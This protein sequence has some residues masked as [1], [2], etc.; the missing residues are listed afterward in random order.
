VDVL[1]LVRSNVYFPVHA[2]GLKE[3]AGHLGFAWTA[4]EASGLQSVVWRR[5]WEQGRDDSY[6]QRLVVYNAE[7]CAALRLVTEHLEMIAANFDRDGGAEPGSPTS[8]ERVK[9]SKRGSDFRKWGHTAFLLPEFERASKCAWFDYQ[10]EKIVARR[11][12]KKATPLP[13][14]RRKARQPRPTKRVEVTSNRCPGCK[15]R[16]VCK[17]KSRRQT[18]VFLDLKVSEGGIR[19][20]VIKYAATK[21]RCR[22]CG[23]YFLELVGV[24][25][26]GAP[27][28]QPAQQL[29]HALAQAVALLAARLQGRQRLGEHR[30]E[31]GGVVGHVGRI[32]GGDGCGGGRAHTS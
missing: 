14:H 9:A 5:R 4:P 22:D 26:L 20:V 11:T 21:H 12:R 30:L 19:R 17:S 29:V 25:A 1:S 18:K 8:T 2:N 3:I 10:R 13:A 24:E 15:S 27:A 31:Q 16:N 28:E 32:D 7:D 6:K 23:R